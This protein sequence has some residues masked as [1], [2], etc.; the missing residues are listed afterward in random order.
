MTKVEIKERSGCTKKLHIEIERER[1][2]SE[3]AGTL[4]K[5]KKDIQIPGFRKGRAPEAMVIKR[6]GSIIREDAVKE[7][8]PKVLE[9]VWESE[10]FKPVGEPMISNVNFDKDGPITLSVAI[11]EIPEIDSSVFST[12]Q[13]VKKVIE[14]TDDDVEDSVQRFRHMRAKQTEV[15]RG[16]QERDLLTANLQR[17]DTAGVPIIGEKM[18]N[19]VIDLNPEGPLPEDIIKQFEGM[20]VGERRNIRFVSTVDESTGDQ[21]ARPELFEAETTKVMENVIPELND[22]LFSDTGIYTDMADFREKTRGHLAGRAEKMANN[23]LNTTLI[24]EFVKQAPFEVPDSMVMRILYSELDNRK[25]TMPDQPVDEE[26]FL[27]DMR[28]DAVRIV[29][30][31]L[32]IEAIKEQNSI[33]VSRDEM[34]EHINK[35]AEEN[36]MNPKELRREFIKD[37]SYENIRTSLAR[38]KAYE[39]MSGQADITIE[40]IDRNKEESNIIVPNRS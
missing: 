35:L 24:D 17:L 19:E 38:N 27:R 21:P 6:F 13:A 39:W 28:P 32:I 15:D 23:A 16:A 4:K 8:I 34:S 10:G 37:G 25:K 40:N 29:Q 7:L 26:A 2:N 5:L 1:V 18:E 14:I 11:E 3:F 31:Y 33:E 22:E 20:K 30:T 9:E 12:V 36:G